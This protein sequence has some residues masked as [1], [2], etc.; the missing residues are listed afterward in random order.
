MS[1]AKLIDI[2][3]DDKGIQEMLKSPEMVDILDNLG[4]Q[5]ALQAGPGYEHDTHI[6]KKRAVCH[7]YPGTKEAAHDNYENNTLEKV[8]SG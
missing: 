6:F 1:R 3:L 8:M 4:A 5:K 7:V 2:E